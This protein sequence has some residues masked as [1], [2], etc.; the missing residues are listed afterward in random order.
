[1]NLSN[2]QSIDE[3]RN[4]IEDWHTFYYPKMRYTKDDAQVIPSGVSTK[5]LY[6]DLDYDIKKCYDLDNSRFVAPF[7]G[8]YHICAAILVGAENFLATQ[9]FRFYAYKNNIDVIRKYKIIEADC[10]EY[11]QQDLSSDMYLLKNEY[12]EIFF[13]HNFGSDVA[14]HLDPD[15]NYFSVHRI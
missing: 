11:I 12:I 7:D 15:Y 6:D 3:I 10:T 14:L 1:M 9:N 8:Y 5:I 4:I 2:V 13:S